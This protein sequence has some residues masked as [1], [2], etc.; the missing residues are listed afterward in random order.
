MRKLDKIQ[1]SKNSE[2]SS[3]LS[4]CQFLLAPRCEYYTFGCSSVDSLQNLEKKRKMPATENHDYSRESSQPRG[5]QSIPRLDDHRGT[6]NC[7]LRKGTARDYRGLGLILTMATTKFSGSLDER[8]FTEGEGRRWH[9]VSSLL[10]E[11][12]ATGMDFQRRCPRC[13][14]TFDFAVDGCVV[15]SRHRALSLSLS[16]AP[17]NSRAKA[18]DDDGLATFPSYPSKAFSTLVSSLERLNLTRR[19]TPSLG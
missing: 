9:G 15:Q 13:L 2:Y 18:R 6:A 19:S 16:L 1:S 11:K 10:R 12:R 3:I 4:Y 17:K 8:G 5:K 14:T 7:A